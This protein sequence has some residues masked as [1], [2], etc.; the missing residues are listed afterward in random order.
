MLMQTSWNRPRAPRPEICFAIYKGQRGFSCK[1][2]LGAK[3]V[4]LLPW[5]LQACGFLPSS[6]GAFVSKCVLLNPVP[7][8]STQHGV[9]PGAGFRILGFGRMRQT[10]GRCKSGVAF[11][12]SL[13]VKVPAPQAPPPPSLTC[14]P[15]PPVAYH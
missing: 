2:L 13:W 4:N 6:G 1:C 8:M 11:A 9:A 5:R 12:P 15:K 14:P 10:R 7:H 3:N